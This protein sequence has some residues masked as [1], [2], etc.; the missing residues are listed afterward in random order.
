[1][2]FTLTNTTENDIIVR[3]V[4]YAQ[5]VSKANTKGS[6]VATN[7][8]GVAIMTI[9]RTVLDTPVTVPANDSASITYRLKTILPT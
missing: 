6:N 4:S 5:A 7:S 9:D 2:L 3:E 8:T 1:M